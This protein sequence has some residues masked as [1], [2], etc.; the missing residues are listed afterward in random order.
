MLRDSEASGV[1]I[2]L[3]ACDRVFRHP[4]TLSD[5]SESEVGFAD[6]SDRCGSG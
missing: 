1:G 5:G 3:R 2:E 6:Y 4:Q